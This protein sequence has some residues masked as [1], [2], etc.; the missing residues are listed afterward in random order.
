MRT[1]RNSTTKEQPRTRQGKA[2]TSAFFRSP[3]AKPISWRSSIASSSSGERHR[4][5][6]QEEA[7]KRVNRGTPKMS[8]SSQ[9]EGSNQK[10]RSLTPPVPEDTFGN[11]PQAELRRRRRC[12]R[13]PER[14]V[15]AGVENRA[16]VEETGSYNKWGREVHRSCGY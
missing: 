7:A 9:T 8:S 12:C 13:A 11:E 16:D 10:L 1:A 4:N 3:P 14:G 2:L 15:G 6:R 5:C